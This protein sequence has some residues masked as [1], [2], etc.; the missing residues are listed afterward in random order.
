MALI[1]GVVE[2]VENSISTSYNYIIFMWKLQG[3]KW[4]KMMWIK[5]GFRQIL[6]SF[7]GFR[8]CLLK[9]EKLSTSL[10]NEL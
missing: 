5:L 2:S 7:I 3:K 4:V 8:A 10:F 6:V 1:I 9:N